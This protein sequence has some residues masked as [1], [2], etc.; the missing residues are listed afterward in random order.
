MHGLSDDFDLQ[1][2]RIL[3]PYELLVPVGSGGMAHV[4]AARHRGAGA[5]FALKMLLP[6][7]AENAAFREMFFDEARIAS[8][9][10]HENVART[11]ELVDLDGVLT[12]VME[13]VDGSSMVRML[14]PGAEDHDD[15]PR[16]ALPIR[17][18]VKILAETCA[19]LHAAHEL[20]G[21]DG[22][23]L[24]VVHR[25][26]SPHNVLLTL[27][28]RVKVTDFGVA[29]AI[30]K[31][32]MTIAG[33][34]KGKLAYMSPEQLVGGGVDRRSDIFA[35]GSVLYEATTGER[36][37]Q[38]E[39]DPQVMAAI[40]MGSFAPPSEIV[41]GYPRDLEAILVRALSTEPGAR[42]AT[43]LALKQALEAW[44]AT[45][46]PPIGAPQISALLQ[47]RC[48]QEL[49]ARV[50]VLTITQ[51]AAPAAASG[52]HLRVES[53][54]AMEID[55]RTPTPRTARSNGVGLL[56]AFFA[57]LV[58]VVL[59]LGVLLYVRNARRER[60]AA[61][62]MATLDATATTIAS[63][64][65]EADAAP[66][67]TD[68]GSTSDAALAVAPDEPPA[69]PDTVTLL[70]PAG[71]R[72]SVDGR[73]LPEGVTSVPRPDAGVV[74][75][76]VTADGHEDAIVDVKPS[77]AGEIDVAMTPRPKPRP[78]SSAPKPDPDP[79]VAMPPNPYD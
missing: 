1:P 53:G 12:L 46:G 6:H 4:W 63:S 75:V 50:S 17:H 65:A 10:R 57:V 59:G 14:R 64:L 52:P 22:R 72:L 30:G 69:A 45:S 13:W 38:G 33:Q 70:V 47:E 3:G 8:R 73:A 76:L 61:A 2:G 21:D 78:R 20:V 66:A 42:Y 74:S 41:R 18:A 48:G 5:V 19:G 35:L 67:A 68:V 71:A 23:P 40:V 56:G 44:L 43:A 29:K 28:G 31:S 49:G 37:F 32:H 16:V 7:L 58:G 62:E 51:P 77:S 11:F 27:D 25:D 39:H 36:P 79:T 54:G 34:V 60:R 9:I 24:A 26:V 55:R 15:A